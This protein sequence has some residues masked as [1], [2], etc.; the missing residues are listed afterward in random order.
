MT[1]TSA[2]TKADRAL[3]AA[4]R[5][6][7]ESAIK[8]AL[9]NG[10]N[11]ECRGE[12]NTTPLHL[13]CSQGLPGA[14]RILVDAGANRRAV[15]FF[16]QD[17]VHNAVLNG[18]LSCL[19]QLL[20]PP[21]LCTD[22][23]KF[24]KN[25]LARDEG[26]HR[27]TSLHVA[28]DCASEETE[29]M[30]QFLLSSG[31]KVNANGTGGRR[32]LS[33]AAQAGSVK[34][35]RLLLTEGAEINH[36]DDEQMSAVH[37]AMKNSRLEVAKLLISC[38]ALFDRPDAHG[39]TPLHAAVMADFHDGA[40]LLLERGAEPNKVTHFGDD[41]WTCSR[42]PAM[43]AILRSHQAKTRLAGVMGIAPSACRRTVR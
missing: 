25:L 40:A 31:L 12:N 17:A 4:I 21:P 5:R 27:D 22:T 7:S 34:I 8:K 36:C 33:Y 18:H 32:P 29:P 30:I 16:N 3:R 39:Y 10:A 11:L 37:W 20:V 38:G 35:V 41:A 2:L 26:K 43:K 13:A 14:V 28:C 19:E 42:S 15:D 23:H 24:Q 1:H 6:Q 9:A